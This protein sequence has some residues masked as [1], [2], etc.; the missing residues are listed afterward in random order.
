MYGSTCKHI[1]KSIHTN[2]IHVCL[3][4]G[5]AFKHV[6]KI[7]HLY[8]SIFLNSGSLLVCKHGGRVGS[9]PSISPIERKLDILELQ[10]GCLFL[11]PLN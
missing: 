3:L 1:S 6:N 8:T 9:L 10:H 4:T 5:I 11:T 7:P 2:Y